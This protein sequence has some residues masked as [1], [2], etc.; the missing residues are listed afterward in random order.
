MYGG[1]DPTDS[2]DFF[3]QLLDRVRE[4]RLGSLYVLEDP[5]LDVSAAIDQFPGLQIKC[6]CKFF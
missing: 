4:E 2:W 6:K 1:Y 5:R 3:S